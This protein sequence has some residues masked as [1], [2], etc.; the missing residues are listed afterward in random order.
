MLDLSDCP[1]IDSSGIA[2]IILTARSEDQQRRLVLCCLK[3]QAKR[4]LEVAGVH[5]HVET[6][7]TREEALAELAS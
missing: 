1:F 5:D 2:V 3:A 6:F 4:V 7:G